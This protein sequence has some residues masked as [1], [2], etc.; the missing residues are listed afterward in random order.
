MAVF[1]HHFG[2]ND[3][4]ETI[5]LAGTFLTSTVATFKVN[6]I[7]PQTLSEVTVADDSQR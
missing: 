3:A 2:A 5:V 7:D 6:V 1:E 4:G